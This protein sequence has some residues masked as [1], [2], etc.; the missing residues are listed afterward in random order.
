M[1]SSFSF[2]AFYR[3]RKGRW[4]SQAECCCQAA[5]F[6]GKMGWRVW[7][8]TVTPLGEAPGLTLH[9]G[10]RQ[11]TR[12]PPTCGPLPIPGWCDRQLTQNVFASDEWFEFLW[13]P[14]LT[15]PPGAVP[16]GK[17]SRGIF[18]S[19]FPV[20]TFMR[21]PWCFW[22]QE[23]ERSFDEKSVP[24][25]R[26]RNAAVEQRLRRLQDRSHT[27]PVTPEEV[28]IAATWVSLWGSGPQLWCLLFT[29]I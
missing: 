16:E 11:P 26:P 24:K 3:W 19:Q 27:Q 20:L 8:E 7:V 21:I 29:K 10:L 6:Q 15:P 13:M 22:S 5:A 25:R 2:V 28:V 18:P 23:M 1:T 9:L 12:L 4:T 14:P 17:R